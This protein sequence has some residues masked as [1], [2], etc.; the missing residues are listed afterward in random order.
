MSQ[1]NDLDPQTRAEIEAM[2][3]DNSLDSLYDV[4]PTAHENEIKSIRPKDKVMGTILQV[5]K[6][7]VL[8]ELGPKQEGVCPLNQF[9][10]AGKTPKSGDREEFMV[11]RYSRAD[12]LYYLSVIGAVQKANWEFLDIGQVVEAKCI[13]V[14]KGGLEMEIAS[15]RAFM[16]AGQASIWHV[17]N[18]ED[19]INE[20]MACE[21]IEMDKK[22]GNIVLSRRA[23]MERERAE[24]KDKLWDD[25]ETGQERKGTVRKLMPFG[26]F[27]DIGGVDGLIHIADLSYQ[28]VKHPSEVVTEGQTVTVQI[29]TLDRENQR[30]GLGLK[31]TQADPYDN[32]VGSIIP[33]SEITGRITRITNFGAFVEIQPGV[34]GLIHIS[35]LSHERVTRVT[36]VVQEDQIVTAQVLDVDLD[37]RRISLSMKAMRESLEEDMT[38]AD[39]PSMAKLRAKFGSGP[40]KLKGGLEF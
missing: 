20:I 30:I 6:E 10:N 22:S 3:S 23:V 40:D 17:D 18:L 25:I 16:P 9:T 11:Q 13:A 35:E 32:A 39:D 27:V 19:L 36:Q 14:N 1:Y 31:Q 5:G 38:R 26:A 8:I 12:G 15:H 29:L 2:M 34:E 7:D 33:G 4:Q 24:L 21:V 28:R 37:S